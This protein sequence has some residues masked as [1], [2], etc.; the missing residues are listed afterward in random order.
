M[1]RGLGVSRSLVTP[2]SQVV[3]GSMSLRSGAG[4]CIGAEAWPSP[5]GLR[6]GVGREELRAHRARDYLVSGFAWFL[7]RDRKSREPTY[8]RKRHDAGRHA[9]GRFGASLRQ[10]T[11]TRDGRSGAPARGRYMVATGAVQTRGGEEGGIE[12]PPGRRHIPR[13]APARR[14]FVLTMAASSHFGFC[15]ALGSWTAGTR[16]LSFALISA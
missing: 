10:G 11:G 14:L 9:A 4:N 12:P 15:G 8:I 5:W 1:L 2:P 16:V 13:K 6:H 7:P 3:A